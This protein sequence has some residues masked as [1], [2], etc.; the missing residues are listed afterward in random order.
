MTHVL[1]EISELSEK[2]CFYIVERHKNKFT[3]PLHCHREYELNFICHGAGVR[4]IVGD[5][6]ETISEYEL[7]LVTGEG[8][9]HVWEQ[10][11]CRSRDIREITIQFS[12]GL[13]DG[14]LLSKNQFASIKGM[15]E[16]AGRGLAFPIEAIMKVY[17]ILDTIASEE[18]SFKQFMLCVEV[19]HEL[20]LCEG[21]VLA[22]SSFAKA[23]R[24]SESRRIETVKEYVAVHYPERISLADL[25]AM[26]NMSPSSFSRFFKMRTGRTVSEYLTDIRLGN[27]ARALVDTTEGVSEICYAC[28]F[29]NL[30]NFNRIFKARRGLSPRE[31]RQLYRKKKVIV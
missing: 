24:G 15:F 29:N 13:F 30:S 17:S 12:P 8:L 14:N 28:G 23:P 9:E 11:N 4:R 27:A 16:R 20:S 2:D 19:L 26:T 10:G 5:S 22:S 1:S 18:D 21:K 7:V 25:A 3:Y 31:F 6:V